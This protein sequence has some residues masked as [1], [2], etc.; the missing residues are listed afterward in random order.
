MTQEEEDDAVV[1]EL[2]NFYHA[3]NCTDGEI[4]ARIKDSHARIQAIKNRSLSEK[5]NKRA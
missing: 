1:A 4:E 3:Q 5:E 2:E